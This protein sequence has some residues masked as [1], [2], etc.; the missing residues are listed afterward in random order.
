MMIS[1]RHPTVTSQE[2]DDRIGK[3]AYDAY[4]MQL[5]DMMPPWDGLSRHLQEAW[6]TA[7]RTVQ[8]H[9]R[10]QAGAYA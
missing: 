10:A 1:Q 8:A 5:G 7:A 2:A 3:L 4:C 6:I 9:V